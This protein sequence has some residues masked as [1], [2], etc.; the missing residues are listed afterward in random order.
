MKRFV[1][2]LKEKK[3][4]VLTDQLLNDHV[5]HL[6]ELSKAGSLITCGPFEDDTGAIQILN[7]ENFEAANALVLNDPFV[8]E[9]YY[10]SFN[11]N[12]FIEASDENNWLMEHP[13]TEANLAE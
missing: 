7:A 2:I 13:Q 12:E 3:K 5:R 9:G 10:S 4:G 11:L 6:A 1:A 8:A